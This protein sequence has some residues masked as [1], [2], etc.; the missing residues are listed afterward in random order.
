MIVQKIGNQKLKKVLMKKEFVFMIVLRMIFIFTNIKIN[1][2]MIAQME[3][4]YLM[5][6]KDA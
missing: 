5:I 3:Q 4:P 2:T 6:I 1:A